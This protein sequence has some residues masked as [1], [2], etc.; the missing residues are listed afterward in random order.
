M[1]SIQQRFLIKSGL[2]WRANGIKILK[3]QKCGGINCDFRIFLE[4]NCA[5]YAVIMAWLRIVLR[6]Y[7][8]RN[9][10]NANSLMGA[11]ALTHNLSLVTHMSMLQLVTLIELLYYCLIPLTRFLHTD[12]IRRAKKIWGIRQKSS[13]FIRKKDCFFVGY[14]KFF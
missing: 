11:S 5:Y 13:L 3:Q 8:A 9:D 1:V 14:P 2:Q 7:C 12:K 4:P 10:A 6:L